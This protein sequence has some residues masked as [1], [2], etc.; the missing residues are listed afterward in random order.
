[1]TPDRPEYDPTEGTGIYC[2]HCGCEMIIEGVRYMCPYCGR[3]LKEHVEMDKP[4]SGAII[5]IIAV[6]VIAVVSAAVFLVMRFI[7]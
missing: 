7:K 4:K 5:F 1:M 6:A 3:V 2:A